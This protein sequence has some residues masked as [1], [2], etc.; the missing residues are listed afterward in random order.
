MAGQADDD[1]RFNE[2]TA[3]AAKVIAV[4]IPMAVDADNLG[5][6]VTGMSTHVP[7]ALS[8]KFRQKQRLSVAFDLAVTAIANPALAIKKLPEQTACGPM[9]RIV[10]AS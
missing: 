1:S 9:P 2:H 5:S 3:F 4:G 6:A 8:R 7:I 10:S